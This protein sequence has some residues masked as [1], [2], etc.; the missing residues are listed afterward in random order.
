MT[1]LVGTGGIFPR[2]GLENLKCL[3]DIHN[4]MRVVRFLSHCLNFYPKGGGK[5]FLV[6]V[7]TSFQT[8]YAYCVYIQKCLWWQLSSALK[9]HYT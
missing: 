1:L 7:L 8:S 6:G 5:K 9:M 2:P 4:K 3:T